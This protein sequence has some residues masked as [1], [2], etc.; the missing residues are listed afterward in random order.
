MRFKTSTPYTRVR[1]LNHVPFTEL[2]TI[3][4]IEDNWSQLSWQQLARLQS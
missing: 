3:N 1:A 4:H 2:A